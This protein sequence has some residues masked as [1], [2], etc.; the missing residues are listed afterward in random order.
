MAR[1]PRIYPGPRDANTHAWKI[2]ETA[3]ATYHGHAGAGDIAIPLSAIAALSLIT[4]NDVTPAEIGAGFLE[5]TAEQLADTIRSI[6]ESVARS[7]PD[8]LNPVWPLMGVWL[9]E[10]HPISEYQLKAVHQAV[11]TAVRYDLFGLTATERRH[12]VDLLGN[13]L[14]LLRSDSA[15]SGLGQFF[16]PP[17]VTEVMARMVLADRVTAEQAVEGMNVHEPAVGTGGTFRAVAE[18]IR[19]HGGYPHRSSWTAVDID[20][21][22][23]AC[24][25]VNVISWGLGYRV[26]LGVGDALTDDWQ[27]RAV[28]LRKETIELAR[29]QRQ[30]A[31]LGRQCSALTRLLAGDDLDDVDEP[32]AA[33]EDAAPAAAAEPVAEAAAGDEGPADLEALMSQFFGAA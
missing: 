12:E 14:T 21:V 17:A 32:A 7:R 26:L 6:W 5:L 3:I 25:A 4:S 18:A 10:T 22:A 33:L 29:T 13:V 8:L 9:D 1:P 30:L 11:L 27:E 2:A 24:L 28:Q 20:A 23:V 16:T 15:R 19:A 31:L